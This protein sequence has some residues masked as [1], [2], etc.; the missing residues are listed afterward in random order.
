MLLNQKSVY[1][2]SSKLEA[3]KRKKLKTERVK[4]GDASTGE[5]LGPWAP[6]KGE[7]EFQKDF[8]LTEEQR[9]NLEEIEER[10]KE[11]IEKEEKELEFNPSSVFHIE[12]EIDY[13][14]RGF[15]RPR[16]NMLLNGPQTYY[17][18]KKMVHIYKGHTK[19]V[20]KSLFFP[21]YGQFLLTSSFDTTVKLWEVN[22]KRRCVVT[23]RGHKG[24]VKDM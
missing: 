14:G 24:A 21:K 16:H 2:K 13:Q 5:F 10:R 19:G 12:N 18:P 11:E 3:E 6:Y 17:I 8:E 7:E 9:K 22:Q 23:F 1:A 15:I 20:L 4:G